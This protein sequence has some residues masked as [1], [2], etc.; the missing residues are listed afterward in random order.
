MSKDKPKRKFDMK[1]QLLLDSQKIPLIKDPNDVRI[2]HAYTVRNDS[3]VVKR[4]AL[5][6]KYNEE[7]MTLNPKY[8]EELKPLNKIL[9]RCFLIEP[10]RTK[11]G[12]IIPH[13]ITVSIP[14]QSGAGHV[15]EVESPF[16]YSKQAVVV[17][18]PDNF[19]LFDQGDIVQLNGEPIH[20]IPTRAGKGAGIMIRHGFCHH[21]WKHD[22]LPTNVEDE[23]YGYL[24]IPTHM[25]DMK[26]TKT[27]K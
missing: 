14:T 2:G 22:H 21:D 15:E 16:P 17:A 8:S 9:V 7:V 4:E 25:I 1:D 13:T 6:K 20:P 23:H 26:I 5:L 10:T 12:M 11:S 24:L 19:D 18:V 3:S 27:T